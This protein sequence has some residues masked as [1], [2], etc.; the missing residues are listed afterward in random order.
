MNG[1]AEAI[2]QEFN[3]TLLINCSKSRTKQTFFHAFLRKIRSIPTLSDWC[4]NKEIEEIAYWDNETNELVRLIRDRKLDVLVSCGAP[5][6]PA[7]LISATPAGIVNLHPSKLPDYRGG[8]PLLWQV[9]D[10][11]AKGGVTAHFVDEFID[12]GAILYQEEYDIPEGSSEDKLK[13]IYEP[14]SVKVL[15]E[16]LHLVENGRGGEARMQPT[17]SAT[18]FARILRKKDVLN[19]LNWNDDLKKAW[20]I[21]RF[22]EYWPFELESPP[23]WRKYFPWK[24]GWYKQVERTVDRESQCTPAL[25]ND[26]NGFHYSISSGIIYLSM[27]TSPIKILRHLKAWA[28][29][30]KKMSASGISS[31]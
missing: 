26:K 21:L 7:E 14:L 17:Q 12:K 2:N 18:P 10:G 25:K 5:I 6:F 13:S 4:K 16:A 20:R 9:M 8:S 1:I 24:I 19:S 29:Y 28:R 3:I 27:E 31:P 15:F 11:I 22:Y 23:G 30:Q